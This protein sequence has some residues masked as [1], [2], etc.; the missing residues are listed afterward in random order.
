MKDLFESEGIILKQ[1]PHQEQG[2]LSTIL[3][4]QFGLVITY[5]KRPKRANTPSHIYPLAYGHFIFKPSKGS[6]TKII[7]FSPA[8]YLPEIRSNLAFLKA[9]LKTFERI[10]YHPMTHQEQAQLYRLL[11]QLLS[12][13]KEATYPENLDIILTIK[14]LKL[15]GIIPTTKSEDFCLGI[16][17]PTIELILEIAHERSVKKLYQISIPKLFRELIKEVFSLGH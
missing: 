4:D 5:H 2:L 10:I 9:S 15:Q 3:T 6:T 1:I 7:E 12:S 14:I 13:L 16:D 17:D 11:M 8:G